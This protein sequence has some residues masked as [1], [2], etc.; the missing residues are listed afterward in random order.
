LQPNT[1]LKS[2]I[3]KFD[4]VRSFYGDF[5]LST[6]YVEMDYP[7]TYDSKK[8][9]KNILEEFLS[10]TAKYKVAYMSLSKLLSS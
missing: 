9:M 4:E 1:K 5:V 7:M 8:T 2:L 10:Y 3:R 6:H